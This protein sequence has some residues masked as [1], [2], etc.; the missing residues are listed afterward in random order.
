M[1][2][3]KEWNRDQFSAPHYS[4]AIDPRRKPKIWLSVVKRVQIS[5]YKISL[6]LA[7]CH[8]IEW[9]TNLFP[10]SSYGKME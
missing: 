7:I 9:K 3:L 8:L 5:V 2:R 1:K 6:E 4:A 10:G